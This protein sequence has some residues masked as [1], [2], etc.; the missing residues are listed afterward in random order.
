MSRKVGRWGLATALA[1]LLFWVGIESDAVFAALTRGWQMVFETIGLGSLLDRLQ[2]GTSSQ[3][4]KRS[5]PAMLTYGVLYLAVCLL[6]LRLVLHDVQAWRLAG[7]IYAGAVVLCATLL[8]LGKLGGNVAV[9]YHAARRL[10]D[11]LVSPV[12][13]L[14]LIPLLSPAVRRLL[15]WR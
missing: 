8:L 13:V 15:G 12:P 11:F 10:I 1:L 2:Q 3:V 5:L 4:T 9:L 7:Q 14:V 6:L